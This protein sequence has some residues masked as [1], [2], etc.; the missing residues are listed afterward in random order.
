MEDDAVSRF[1]LERGAMRRPPA[2]TWI[3]LAVLLGCAAEPIAAASATAPDS[4]GARPP[5]L[6][7]ARDLWL[8]LAAGAGIVAT[9][10][11]DPAIREE[12]LESRSAMRGLSSV[13]EHL[14]NPL[15]LGSALALTHLAAARVGRPD[16]EIAADRVAGAVL[17]A[18][19]ACE[20][21][22]V[23]IGRPRPEQAG[24]EHDR[25]RPFSRYDS[26]PSG[27]ATVAFAAAAALDHESKAAWVPWVAYP[28]AGLV[29]WSRVHDDR[30]WASDVVAGAALGTWVG[31][32]AAAWEDRGHGRPIHVLLAPLDGALLAGLRLHF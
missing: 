13:A 19:L 9:F 15:Y 27:H 11:A 4:G 23:S 29:G 2:L 3:A 10:N 12:E 5:S 20:V 16:V 31:L 24:G 17:V 21:L 8:G 7:S 14:G 30:H 28:L 32:K 6:V 25:A 1:H 26:F 18:G 22:K